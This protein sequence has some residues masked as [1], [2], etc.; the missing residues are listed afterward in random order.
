M[1]LVLRGRQSRESHEPQGSLQNRAIFC[2]LPVDPFSSE[3]FG[4][5]IALERRL[6]SPWTWSIPKHRLFEQLR[7]T[8]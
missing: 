3:K 4:A 8:A 7:K 6:Q 2:F 5:R 1:T